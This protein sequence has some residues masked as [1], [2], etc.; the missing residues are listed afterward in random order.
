[1][2]NH[3]QK[4]HSL[5]SLTEVDNDGSCEP[6][7]LTKAGVWIVD[8]KEEHD[9]HCPSAEQQGEMEEERGHLTDYVVGHGIVGGY[10]ADREG[11]EGDTEVD[12]ENTG[13][14]GTNTG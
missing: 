12:Q 10:V 2:A 14:G 6:N 8:H 7:P 5:F 9:G 11:H 4:L 13:L 1:M 3:P